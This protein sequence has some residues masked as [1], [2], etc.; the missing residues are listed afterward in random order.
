MFALEILDVGKE[1]LAVTG[2]SEKQKR[3]NDLIGAAVPSGL[4]ALPDFTA[5][6]ISNE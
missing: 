1:R 5:D 6:C 2:V 3:P 4:P